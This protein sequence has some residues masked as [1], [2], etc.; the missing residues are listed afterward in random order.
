M[1]DQAL[2]T[3]ERRWLGTGSGQDE[4]ALLRARLRLGTIARGRLEV[5]ALLGHAP[6]R[7]A[8][9]AG[10]PPAPERL[11]ELL[12]ALRGRGLE[13]ELRAAAAVIR[14][15]RTAPRRPKLRA[16][17]PGFERL[18]AARPELKAWLA[19]A[20][21]PVPAAFAAW[22][23]WPGP[24]VPSPLEQLYTMAGGWRSRSKVSRRVAP[25]VWAAVAR[26]LVPWALGRGDP[27]W[28]RLQV[29]GRI[30]IKPEDLQA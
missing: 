14:W 9:G 29:D 18:A 22:R 24:P 6:A 10:A 28:S 30:E 20:P 17:L 16:P 26:A 7:H 27:V 12:R 1:A 5:A 15:R 8:L 11:E 13:V 21:G 3:R 23:R 2:R 19:G 4:A 25:V